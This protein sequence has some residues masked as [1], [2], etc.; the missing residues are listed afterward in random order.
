M[1]T[2]ARFP[3][4]FVTGEQRGG[5]HSPDSWQGTEDLDVAMLGLLPLAISRRRKFL[6]QRLDVATAVDPLSVHEPQAGQ[7]ERDVRA[8]GLHCARSDLQGWCF[9]LLEDFVGRD[10]PDA[11]SAQE[12][13]HRHLPDS[14][15]RRGGGREL[16]ERPEPGL[17]GG[18]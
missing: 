8:R 7:Q 11:V 2:W 16:D 3:L 10:S 12:L 9:Q 14:R 13:L 5:H 17:V 15:C 18:R 1:T 6:E 4:C